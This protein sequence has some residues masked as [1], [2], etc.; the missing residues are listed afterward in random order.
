MANVALKNT[1]EEEL[2]GFKGALLKRLKEL[3]EKNGKPTRHYI[4]D[5][6]A[7]HCEDQDDGE[8]AD[9]AILESKGLPTYT[10]AEVR[11]LHG[12]DNR[13]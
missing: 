8:A 9:A 12:L 13:L 2:F 1:T 6:L 10:L 11:R 4:V 7:Q 3:A 5:I